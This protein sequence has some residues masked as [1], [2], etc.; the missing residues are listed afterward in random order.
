MQSRL[1][2]LE[3]VV[4]KL[5]GA[6]PSTSAALLPVAKATSDDDD[7]DDDELD[8]FGSDEEEEEKRKERLK[9]YAEQKAKSKS[10]FITVRES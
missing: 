3:E 2:K 7:D 9:W 6:S 4:N 5:T 1:S 8:F 10:I